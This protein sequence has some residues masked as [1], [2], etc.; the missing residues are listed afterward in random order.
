MLTL[1]ICAHC[2]Q[3]PS[4]WSEWLVGELVKEAKQ[5]RYPG[6]VFM[7]LAEF[8]ATAAEL[9]RTAGTFAYGVDMYRLISDPICPTFKVMGPRGYVLV[10]LA[11]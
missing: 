4:S 7:P 11:R 2:M 6:T 8:V 3:V 1:K 10:S 9:S 5:N